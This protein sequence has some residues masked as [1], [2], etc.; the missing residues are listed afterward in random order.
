MAIMSASLPGSIVPMRSDRLQ[1]FRASDRR[2]LQSLQRCHSTADKS[3]HFFWQILR[4][5]ID[6]DCDFQVCF[7]CA[8]NGEA[9]LFFNTTGNNNT[10]VGTNALFENVT[11]IENTAN[12]S[13]ALRSNTTGHDNTANGAF[14]SMETPSVTRTRVLG[15]PH[16]LK[17]RVGIKILR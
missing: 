14:A 2:C 13:S 1:Q 12:G 5:I 7:E 9:A 8:A 16:F 15:M 4:F 11:G 10:A 6:P 17:I 3:F